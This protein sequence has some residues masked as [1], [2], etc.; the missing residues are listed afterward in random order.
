MK[1][2]LVSVCCALM[3]AGCALPSRDSAPPAGSPAPSEPSAPVVVEHE[4]A[5][6]VALWY[7]PNRISDLLAEP[8]QGATS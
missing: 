1:L 7:I 6:H 8:D 5:G 4:D 2:P 3:L